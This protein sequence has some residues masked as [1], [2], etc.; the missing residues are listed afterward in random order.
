MTAIMQWEIDRKR[1]SALK[2][3]GIFPLPKARDL[4]LHAALDDVIA[5]GGTLVVVA[6]E[7]KLTVVQRADTEDLTPSEPEDGR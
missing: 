2:D 7:D 1:F 4:I 5:N 6:T 3:S